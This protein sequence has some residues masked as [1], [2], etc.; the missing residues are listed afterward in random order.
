MYVYVPCTYAYF[1]T[2]FILIKLKKLFKI[3]YTNL[4]I[5]NRKTNLT[6]NI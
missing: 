3:K 4:K 6:K 1:T 2:Y 5:D